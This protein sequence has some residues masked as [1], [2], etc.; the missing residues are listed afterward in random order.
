MC[1]FECTCLRGLY[2]C[3]LCSLMYVSTCSRV[4][5]CVRV[6]VRCV[7]VW[8]SI[9]VDILHWTNWPK[10]GEKKYSILHLYS[11]FKNKIT[12][13]F[14]KHWFSFSKG[15]HFI[16]VNRHA[17]PPASINRPTT[18]WDSATILKRHVLFFKSM[19]EGM[20]CRLEWKGT[21]NSSNPSDARSVTWP[22]HTASW[23][24]RVVLEL[25]LKL[26]PIHSTST[27]ERR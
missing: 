2:V 22:E 26:L 17:V 19:W 23:R 18:F 21:H 10:R 12:L 6:Y 16:Y 7:G 15:K 20:T 27:T 8:I 4:L 24:M 3:H 13:Q 5:E 1:V 11:C 9:V 14:G 25:V